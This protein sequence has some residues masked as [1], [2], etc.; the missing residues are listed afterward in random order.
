[1]IKTQIQLPDAL[2]RDLKQVAKQRE[3]SLAEVIRRGAEY[4][5]QVYRP[6]EEGRRGWTLPG[7]L[8]V[9]VKKDLFDDPGWRAEANVGAG[10]LALVGEKSKVYGGRRKK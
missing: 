3:M 9:G 2:Y 7:P 5:T 4:I 10:S 1:M 8:D 6:L